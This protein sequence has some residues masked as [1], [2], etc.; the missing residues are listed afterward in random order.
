MY[1][2]RLRGLLHWS[3][4]PVAGARSHSAEHHVQ[5]I[6]ADFS[7]FI[8]SF[9]CPA[10]QLISFSGSADNSA[11]QIVNRFNFNFPTLKQYHRKSSRMVGL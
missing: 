4:F 2:H 3:L 1:R 8:N 10:Y 11:N 5:E 7:S 6:K 9:Y